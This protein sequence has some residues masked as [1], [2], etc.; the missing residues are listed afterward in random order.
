MTVAWTRGAIT[1]EPPAGGPTVVK[2]G[3]SLLSRAGWPRE[4][5]MLLGACG[6]PLTVVVGG[7]AVV[8]GLRAIDAACPR[9]GDVMHRLAID[10]LGLTA[11]LVA[12]ATALPLAAEPAADGAAVVLDVPVWLAAAGRGR[13]LPATWQVTSDSIAA[14]VSASCG[15]ALVLAKSVPPPP[16]SVGDLRSLAR[17]GWIDEHFPDAAAG[18]AHVAWAVPA[19]VTPTNS[20]RA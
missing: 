9:P 7:G 20:R 1:A 18:L 5:A 15:A 12:E 2:F 6:R 4:L 3:G 10:A 16:S 13:S 8:D 19:T 14:V 17:V 11:R